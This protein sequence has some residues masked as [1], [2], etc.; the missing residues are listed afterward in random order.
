MSHDFAR[1]FIAGLVVAGV[2]QGCDRRDGDPPSA[3]IGG[4]W[5]GEAKKGWET[6]ELRAELELDPTESS[7]GG[8]LFWKLPESA[9]FAP[10]GPVNGTLDANPAIVGKQARLLTVTRVVVD[11]MFLNDVFTGSITF[12]LSGPDGP[13]VADVRLEKR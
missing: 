13:I 1:R 2:S 8:A 3:G 5:G 11:G 9:Q 12:P 4:T 6:L 7:I 10:A